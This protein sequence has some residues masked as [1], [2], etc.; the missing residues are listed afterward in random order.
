MNIGISLGYNCDPAQHGV[1]SG[2]RLRREDGY[3]TCPFDLM[4]S[5]YNGI[6]RCI[7][8]DFSDFLNIDY[9]KCIDGVISNRKYYFYF[10]HESPAHPFLHTTENWAEGNNH[11][12]NN[13]FKNLISRYEKRINNF[14]NYLN[15]SNNYIKFILTSCNGDD[16]T[17]KTMDDLDE[18]KN[19][20]SIRYPN[21]KYEIILI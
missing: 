19:V 8:D 9:L 12:I 1:A 16:T 5:N 15:D 14:R 21:L 10:N 4:I 6:V 20:L 18:L 17:I 3:K 13:N 7:S 11:F 2:L